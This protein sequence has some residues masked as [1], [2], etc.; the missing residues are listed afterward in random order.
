MRKRGNGEGSIFK[1]KDGRW[2]AALTIGKDAA[3]KPKRK[4]FTADTRHEVNE[5]LTKA[6]R[7]RQLGLPIATEKTTVQTFLQCWLKDVVR[8]SVKPKTY[9][10]YADLVKLHI[11]PALGLRPLSKLSPQD[12]RAFLN[13]KLTALQPSR[14][15]VKEG[16]A[17]MPGKPL[18]ARTVK[19]LLVTLRGA[20]E[21]ATKDGIVPRNVAALVDPPAIVRRQM[22]VFNPE[23]ARIFLEAINGERLE[24]LFTTAIALAYRQGEALGLQWADVDLEAGTLT[25]RQALQRVDGK[26]RLIPTK[27]DKVHTVRLPAITVSALAAHRLRQ[28]QER[29]L[30]GSAWHEKGFVFTSS[31]GTPVDARGVIRCFHA[32]L[33]R[34]PELPRIRFHDLRHSA[35]TLLLAQGVSPKYISDLLGHSQVSFT[36]QTY[37]H[38][39]PHVQREAASKMDEI[40]KPVATSVATNEAKARAN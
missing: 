4:V 40:L 22:K 29:L 26:L 3:G 34:H 39:L 19:H 28:D 31:I 24:A 9:R 12:V 2:R 1:L 25:I 15:K 7:N 20:L 37:A 13:E 16:E 38:V 18:S 10:T 5:E 32:I 8:P 35:A 36:M 27:K 21:S 23:Q 30:A 11:S 14:K 6:L 33:R 17:P